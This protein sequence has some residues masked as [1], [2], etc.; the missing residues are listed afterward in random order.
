[1]IAYIGLLI[2]FTLELLSWIAVAIVVLIIKAFTLA[3]WMSEKVL[4][5]DNTST[6]HWSKS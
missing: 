6:W 2:Y 1:M 5:P 3:K 4:N